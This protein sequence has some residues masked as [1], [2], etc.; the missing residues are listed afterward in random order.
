MSNTASHF[1]SYIAYFLVYAGFYFYLS[2][3]FG[4][5]HTKNDKVSVEKHVNV[6][7]IHLI[8]SSQVSVTTEQISTIGYATSISTKALIGTNT[9][10]TKHKSDHICTCTKH[11]CVCVP[12]F[13]GTNANGH[14]CVLCV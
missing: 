13:C 2:F 9:K 5:I 12:V 4:D 8:E 11:K 10:D 3:K 7:K 6:K 14:F 1:S